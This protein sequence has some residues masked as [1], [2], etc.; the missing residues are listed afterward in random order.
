MADRR[1]GERAGAYCIRAAR[2]WSHFVSLGWDSR[3]SICRL[4][5]HASMNNFHKDAGGLVKRVVKLAISLLFYIGNWL[6]YRLRQIAGGKLPGTCVVLYYHAVPIEQ[7][8][9][10]A[11]QMDI[12]SR[13]ARPVRSDIKKPLDSG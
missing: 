6:W 12:L 5:E 8:A 13:W 1:P 4:V 3:E 9:K 7:Q 10:F 11:R 2:R